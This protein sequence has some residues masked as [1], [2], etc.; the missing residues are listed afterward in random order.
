MDT[1]VPVEGEPGGAKA[2]KRT[3]SMPCRVLG[4]GLTIFGIGY[5]TELAGRYEPEAYCLRSG[6]LAA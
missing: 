3:I 5:S 4:P 1:C 2:Q 6:G